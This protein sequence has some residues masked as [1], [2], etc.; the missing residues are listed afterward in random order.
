MGPGGVVD[1]A[2]ATV[3]IP[4]HAAK[5]LRNKGTFSCNTGYRLSG[6]SS[7]SCSSSGR[8]SGSTASCLRI[9]CPYVSPPAHCSMIGGTSYGD[10]LTFT[11][12]TGFRLTGSSRLT[13]GSSGRWSSSPPT[14][15]KVVCPPPDVPPNCD[16]NGG[17]TY[18]DTVTY[19]CNVGYRLDG[20]G[21]RVCLA[22]GVWGDTAPR[23]E[24][25]QCTRL[26]PPTQGTMN[27]GNNYNNTVFFTC[28]EGYILSG[29]SNRTCQADGLWS[30]TQPTC[31]AL[32]CPELDA[33][34]NCDK[35]GGTYVGSFLVFF[36]HNGYDITGGDFMRT[37]EPDQTWSGT[38]P[39]CQLYTGVQCP[40]M[41]PILNGQMSGGT[42]YGQMISFLC[43]S[44]YELSGSSSR[45]CQ[46]DSSWSG[47]QPSCI[48]MNCTE[49]IPP[50][51]GA[52]DGGNLLGDAAVYSCAEGYE[53]QGSVVRF[54]MPDQTWSGEETT[55]Q[56]KECTQ[57][58]PPH[59]GGING[60]N[61]FGDTVIFDCDV[62]YSLVG[63]RGVVW[64]NGRLFR[65]EPSGPG[66]ESP[67]ATDKYS[68][69]LSCR[70]QMA[71]PFGD[72]A[73][74]TCYPGYELAGSSTQ[75][76]QADGT[77]S[78]TAPTCARK[79]CAPLNAPANGDMTGGYFYGDQVTFSCAIGFQLNNSDVRVCG[80]NGIWSGE[81][82]TCEDVECSLLPTPSNSNMIVSGV[83]FGDTANITCEPGYDLVSG[84][85]VR[86]YQASG[87]WSGT[88][89]L[90]QKKCYVQPSLQY[91]TYNGTICYNETIS[92]QCEEGYCFGSTALISCNLGY[93]LNGDA[94][95]LYCNSSGVWEGEIQTCERITCG[96]P[97]EVRN[98]LRILTGTFYGDTVTYI[99][100]PGF[101]LVGNETHVCNE[102]G[103]WGVPPFC[104][105]NSLCNRTHLSVP[106]DGSKVCFDSPQGTT[107]VEYCQ[108]HCNSPLV[109][110]AST[111][112]YEC[113]VE[114]SW[115][116]QVRQVYSGITLFSVVSVG[117]CSPPLDSF[118]L[119]TVGGLIITAGQPLDMQAIADEMKYQLGLLGLCNSP[120]EAMELQELVQVGGLSLSV[121]GQT[122]SVADNGITISNPSLGCKDGEIKQG[123]DC[124]MDECADPNICP[125][126]MC[127]NRPGSYSCQCLPGYE[128]P[129]CADID[130]CR[131]AGFCPDHSICTNTDGDY[132][133][134]CL[135][136]YQGDNCEDCTMYDGKCYIMSDTRG[137][138]VDAET[139]CA[140]EGGILATVKD[141]QVQDFLVQL[142]SVSNKDVWIGLTDQDV[143]G[144][145]V[146]ADGTPLVYSNW[147]PGEPN[148]DD[149]TN[150]VHLWPLANF[151]WHDMP[152]GRSNYYICQY[153][154]A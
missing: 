115:R 81:Q 45:V 100:D 20:T 28:A 22:T 110:S 64:R 47:I 78:G 54:C 27:G 60:T 62:G 91:G 75:T 135:Q 48:P 76:C 33:P 99:C 44:G 101:L 9:S 8:W 39:T 34:L 97:G 119:I 2:D 107:P 102:D 147:A 121:G 67:D 13:C 94:D 140:E 154:M 24:M 12:N 88:P 143:E 120:C 118:A 153:N 128:G 133:C 114:T 104:E 109:Y 68:A 103:Y 134:T 111:S 56:R 125:N 117:E 35:T 49:L 43:N 74:Y 3:G 123:V 136:G 105:A 63:S 145:F 23:C 92:I 69:Q 129:V 126:A 127:I 57:L 73:S 14:C 41:S 65:P 106:K 95:I 10:V 116:W 131:Y 98:A 32:E 4:E 77:W 26:N 87:E 149:T 152:C 11:C 58:D 1:I 16:V 5:L 21:T 25:V 53:I 42:L 70:L 124:Y 122:L 148:G 146:W 71:S 6:S 30:G 46:S 40:T 7:R 38:Q 84:D 17:R 36:C 93:K 151:R 61:Y 96:D 80:D 141:Q 86:T 137:T 37:C 29:S 72:T 31:S 82:P 85:T 52:I 19:T 90:C 132:Y 55:C 50:P 66:F 144:Q 142:L 79:Q 59:N 18:G 150:C 89:G 112:M 130:E 139:K 138:F 108:M 51:D 113:S 15:N 83:S